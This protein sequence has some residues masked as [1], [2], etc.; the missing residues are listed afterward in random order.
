MFT[1]KAFDDCGGYDEDLIGWEDYDLWL[2]MM[3][4]GYI[5]KRIPKPLFVYFHH[6]ND[7]TVST[8]ANQNQQELY[9]NIMYKN[10]DIENGKILV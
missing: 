7:G 2:R 5:G 6:E 4:N 10:F 9:Q 8:K 1:K 3:K